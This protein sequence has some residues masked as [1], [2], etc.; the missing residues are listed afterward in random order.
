M[1]GDRG[2]LAARKVLVKRW[3]RFDVQIMGVAKIRK[4][5]DCNS[6]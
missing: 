1:Q 2:K 4:M 6:Y 3:H 5:I